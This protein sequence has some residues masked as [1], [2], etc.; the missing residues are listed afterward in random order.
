L[1]AV[2]QQRHDAD[3]NHDREHAL[4]VGHPE[5]QAL[6][7]GRNPGNATRRDPGNA[8]RQHGTG[9]QALTAVLL[10]TVFFAPSAPL[11]AGLFFALQPKWD[12]LTSK[13]RTSAMS[14]G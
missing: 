3:D 7:A 12:A 9:D 2:C 13:P 8:A 1:A 6:A 11:A 14:L 4:A 10:F 5:P